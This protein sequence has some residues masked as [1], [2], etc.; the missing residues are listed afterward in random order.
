MMTQTIIEYTILAIVA[1][2]FLYYVRRWI[3]FFR[4][5]WFK[6]MRLTQLRSFC[7][8][9]LLKRRKKFYIAMRVEGKDSLQLQFLFCRE[10]STRHYI[11]DY[12]VNPETKP[13]YQKLLPWVRSKNLSVSEIPN[14]SYPSQSIAEFIAE[15]D[16]Q[17]DF[18]TMQAFIVHVF[19]NVYPTSSEDKYEAFYAGTPEKWI[20]MGAP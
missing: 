1:A 17:S 18:N 8:Y 3:I 15:I 5:P 19:Q 13:Y 12:P 7:I 4:F 9:M 16:F 14:E 20:I 10:N 2:I 6:Q 11:L